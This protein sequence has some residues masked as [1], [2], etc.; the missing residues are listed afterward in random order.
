MYL[1]WVAQRQFLF[2]TDFA[3]IVHTIL[4]DYRID[5]NNMLINI[6]NDEEQ[7]IKSVVEWIELYLNLIHPILYMT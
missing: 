6:C 1:V 4:W 2:L 3:C 5:K 7:T